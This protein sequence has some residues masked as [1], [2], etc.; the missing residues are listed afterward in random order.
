MTVGVRLMSGLLGMVI[1]TVGV[2]DFH[3][4]VIKAEAVLEPRLDR[5]H[6]PGSR[7]IL[8]DAGM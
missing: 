8:S 4:D 1:G 6:G 3:S 2:L 7:S 5:S